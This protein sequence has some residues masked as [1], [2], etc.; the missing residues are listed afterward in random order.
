ME[1]AL[2]VRLYYY[3]DIF[4]APKELLTFITSPLG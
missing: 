4:I 3:T 2:F 1:T